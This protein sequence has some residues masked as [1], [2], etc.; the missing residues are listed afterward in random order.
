MISMKT[1]NLATQLTQIISSKRRC[2]QV[3]DARFL[4]FLE[5]FFQEIP[6][7]SVTL[8]V[9]RCR[10]KTEPETLII[11]KISWELSRRARRTISAASS[12]EETSGRAPN[13]TVH[14]PLC[15]VALSSTSAGASTG[16]ECRNNN[17]ST[18]FR[19]L[20]RLCYRVRTVESPTLM[21]LE[22]ESNFSLKA[23][24]LHSTVEFFQST[25]M[26]N[27]LFHPLNVSF[28]VAQF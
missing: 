24:F 21:S 7:I 20:T 10:C 22:W 4:Y 13:S 17:N 3:M 25:R 18:P 1:R 16:A 5:I 27:C 9:H 19:C 6:R 11:G 23:T 8:V 15:T 28:Q 26:P 12:E 14:T 2:N